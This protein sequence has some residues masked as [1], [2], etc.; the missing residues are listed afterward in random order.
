MRLDALDYDLPPELIAQRPPARRED[1]RLLVVER[2]SGGLHDAR[3]PD[4]VSWLRS[5]DTLALNETRVRP[6][7][8]TLRRQ[9]TGGHVELLFVRPVAAGGS[10]GTDWRVLARPAKRVRPGTVVESEDG[11]LALEVVATGE[12]GERTVRVTRG[13]L[14]A[15]LR[16]QGELALPPYIHRAPEPAD[17]ERY[18]TVFARVDGAVAAPTAGLHL[19]A[20]LLDALAAGGVGAARIVL[21]V[22]PGTFRPITAEDPREHRMDEEY[23]EVSREAAAT[24]IAARAAGGRIVAVGTTVARALESACDAHA[25]RLEAASGWTRKFILPPYTFSAVDALLTNFHL[26]RTTLL[27]LVAALT[28]EDLMRGAYAHAVAERYRFF[29]YGDAMLIV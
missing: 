24:L 4:L 27:L 1:A 22:G 26:P 10:A 21:H 23:F 6:A 19:S 14:D 25:G 12:E 29:S 13:D 28:G 17:R 2:A 15:T 3:I 8:L 16:T 5:G 7:R 18:Q 9:P 20:P 11:A